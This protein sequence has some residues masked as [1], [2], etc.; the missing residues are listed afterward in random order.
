MQ[1]L[2]LPIGPYSLSLRLIA[3]GLTTLLLLGCQSQ[4]AQ[5]IDDAFEV[6]TPSL[7]GS[8]IGFLSHDLLRGRDTGDVGY[9]IGAEYVASQF[10]RLGLSP[11]DG[12]SYLQPFDLLVGEKDL[13]SELQVGSI[14]LKHPEAVF[15]PD[16]LGSEAKIEGRGL[17]VG[18][19]VVS[20]DRDDYAGADPEGKIVFVI[21]GGPS[22]WS[23]DREKSLMARLKNEIAIR[24]GAAAV[25]SL[26]IGDDA[27]HGSVVPE[28]C[29]WSYPMARLLPF[30]QKLPWGRRVH[31]VCS[32]PGVWI[33][34]R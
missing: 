17:Y 7:I 15:N 23:E 32:R 4:T 8:H 1:Y 33:P 16:W 2:R 5:S 18:Y 30:A 34:K 22:D 12:S 11:V 21:P 10:N 27:K 29:P 9:E 3:S 31:N 6:I 13:G 26:R 14:R 24:R 20:E 28:A 19:G 25:V